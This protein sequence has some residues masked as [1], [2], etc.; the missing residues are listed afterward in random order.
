MRSR[1]PQGPASY[2]EAEEIDVAILGEELLGEN[3][4][5]EIDVAQRA[6][7]GLRRDGGE[8]NVFSRQRSGG[9]QPAKLH[10]LQEAQEEPQQ[11]SQQ[12]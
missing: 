10:L 5:K 3:V 9:Q 11:Q 2:G 8:E 4:G 7:N 12:S 1:L 6:E